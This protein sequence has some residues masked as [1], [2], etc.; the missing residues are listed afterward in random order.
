MTRQ[1][2]PGPRPA[3]PD[4]VR[5]PGPADLGEAVARA[6]REGL[7]V[8]QP[9]MGMAGP[10]AM[11]AGLRAVCSL[12]HPTV[13]TLTLDSYT[14]VGDH[15][16]ARAALAAGEPLN[17]FP[18]VA[19]GPHTTARV[20]AAAGDRPVQVRHGS[21]LPRDI[22]RTM[23]AAGLSASEGGPVSYC[24]PYGR[25]PLAES[26]ANWRAATAEFAGL[27]A[28]RGLRAH[29]ETFGGCLLGQLCPPSLLV[30]VSLL[31]ALFF[32]QQ[33]V[34]SVSLSYAQ[35]TDARQDVEALAALRMLADEWLPP[36]VD[37]HLVLYTYMGVFPGSPRGAQLL[38]DRS[39]ELAV[40]GGAQRLIVKTPA[41]AVRLPTVEENVA[42]LRSAARAA[43]RRARGAGPAAGDGRVPYVGEVDPGEVLA[44]ARALVE[45]TLELHADVGTALTRAFAAGLLDV[46]FCLHE[47][48]RGLTQAAVDGEGR[49]RWTRTG[50]LPLPRRTVPHPA[51][52]TAARLLQMLRYT[53]DRHD[54]LALEAADDPDWAELS[55]P[56]PAVRPP[57]ADPEPYRIA[58]VGTGPRGLSVLERL[59][60]RL[61][62]R[63]A[64]RPVEV[65][66]IDAHEVGPGRVWRT[67]QPRWSMMNT[68]SGEV[69]I[70]SGPP[71]DGPARAGA[72]P[73]LYE[74]WREA[75]PEAA[76][77][78]ECA[79]RAVYG[80]Y[81][82]HA[83]D[84][85]E[86]TVPDGVLR[87][88]RLL[89]TVRTLAPEGGRYLL[90][91]D[92]G[93][94][95]RADRV[96]LTTGHPLPRLT[97][98]QQELASFAER[99]PRLTYVRGDSA[100]DMPLD[101]IAPGSV[102]G[103]IGLGLS[104]YDV[105]AALTT[106]R[107]G[108]FV[109]DDGGALRYEASGR[110]PLLVAGARSGV[111]LRARGRNQKGPQHVYRP[112]LFTRER[113]RALRRRGPLDF[114]A[115]VLPW[116]L[117]EVELVRCATA[118]QR[119]YGPDIAER[120]RQEAE[121]AVRKGAAGAGSSREGRGPQEAV[122]GA[123]VRCGLR[124]H[125]PVDLR[126]W[127]WPFGDRVF[128]GPQAYQEELAALL[129]QDVEL[130][131]E[132]NAE[133]PVK[134]CLDTIRDVRGVLRTAVDFSGLAP[135]SHREDFLGDFVPMV[136]RL[137]TGPPLV[138]LRQLLALLDCGLLRV[139][140]PDARFTADPA[141][142]RFQV[143]SPR[144]AGSRTELDVLVDARIPDPDLRRA[145][146]DLTARLRDQGLLTP[147]VNRGPD[148]GEFA[149][150]G[151]AVTGSPFH[152]VRADGRPEK[153]MYVLG[154]PS[155]F[156][157]WFTQVGSGRPGVW[158][159]F[160]A[161]ADA[162]AEDA[163]H[164]A[165]D[166]TTATPLTGVLLGPRWHTALTA[167]DEETNP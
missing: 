127:A 53:A 21:A 123:A 46:P 118:L 50:R 86:R 152:P 119:A 107:G 88:H 25:T 83:L 110:E 33:G 52:V 158:G 114:R 58:V 5:R 62:E 130:A 76:A 113:V 138:R 108:R 154:I 31:E 155:E 56:R 8:V 112:R 59:A 65:Y 26:V 57:E 48:N 32:V 106:G 67:G 14:R 15:G 143:H 78:D 122:F 90:T 164:G 70:Y 97:P 128:S 80:Q 151:V 140:G 29:L 104:F 36:G 161:D 135:R 20:A 136:S 51:P 147:Y 35:Q 159:E 132:G 27:S 34:S 39:A 87:L 69:T 4:A 38:M 19:H 43:G 124:G 148:G 141:S 139:T 101:G 1:S 16:L 40:R 72:G 96:V 134:A 28:E 60:A 84:R 73:S 156:T 12:P 160:A 162:I 166:G 7:L 105:V 37:R 24:L 6:A 103:V 30:A 77:P 125:G 71:D 116:L 100:I 41:E 89:R 23:V 47:D 153:G 64:P 10:D 55:G 129:R 85:I 92:D 120:F 93:R 79:P 91:L 109:P 11:A 131:A 61:A 66:A 94:R 145:D 98:D 18:L 142:G 99:R 149:T 22:F 17:G 126:R 54:L 3:R 95:L 81:L 49:L 75:D 13:G 44:E 115:D 167:P 163:L 111:P 42:A 9:R 157:R 117:A 144:V 63:P 82:A 133:G 2:P 45:A 121:E 102:V 146:G 68:V 150:G 74:W 137:T 165:H